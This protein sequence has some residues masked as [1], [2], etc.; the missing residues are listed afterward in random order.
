M[1]FKTIILFVCTAL[2]S[3]SCL[4]DGEVHRNGKDADATPVLYKMGTPEVFKTGITGLSAVCV[5]ENGDGLYAA[6]DDGLLYEVG[7]DGTVKGTVPFESEHDW[8]GVTVNR[9]D[10]TVF[11]SEERERAVYVLNADRKGVTKLTSIEVPESTDDN[12]GFEG[13]AFGNGN[14]YLANQ[15][16]PKRVFVWSLKEEKVISSFDIEFATYL[17]DIFYDDRDGSLWI[18]DSKKQALTNI[19]PDGS[20][21]GSYDI[22]FVKKPEGFCIDTVQKTFWFCC[23]STGDLYKVSYN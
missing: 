5:N 4:N 8:E 12:R 1:R 23:D 16:L 9:A 3:L 2:A 6:L 17:S 13:I 21:I 10:R 18:T 20:V 11:L 19:R 14:L 7:L 15:A 22:S